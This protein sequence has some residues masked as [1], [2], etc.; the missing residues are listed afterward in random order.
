MPAEDGTGGTEVTGT[1][2]ARVQRDPSDSNWEAPTGGNGIYKNAAAIQFG[3]PTADWGTIV[4]FGL[5]TAS[6]SGTYLLG[7]TFASPVTVSTGDPAP[8]FAAQQL[9]IT[10]A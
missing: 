5:F 2:Y 10:V 7:N 4:G 1:G 6:T 3:S 9:T 8:A